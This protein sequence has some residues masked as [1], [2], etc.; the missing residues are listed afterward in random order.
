MCHRVMV[1]PRGQMIRAAD[2]AEVHR[3]H[4]AS[5]QQ[6]RIDFVAVQADS[7]RGTLEP[8]VAP[9]CECTATTTFVGAVNGD[10]IDGTFV[11]RSGRRE[12]AQGRWEMKHTSAPPG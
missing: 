10:R 6:L 9:D 11:T 1:D 3:L 7:V 12:M 4:V 5:P 8:Y 2:P